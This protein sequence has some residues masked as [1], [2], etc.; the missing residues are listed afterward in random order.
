MKLTYLGNL[1]ILLSIRI[2]G[3]SSPRIDRDRALVARTKHFPGA[4]SLAAR[5]RDVDFA[6]LEHLDDFVRF[7]LEPAGM[8]LHTRHRQ[9]PQQCLHPLVVPVFP[10]R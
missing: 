10:R 9:R 3:G 1:A 7:G 8:G 4:L 6:W 5:H 2:D